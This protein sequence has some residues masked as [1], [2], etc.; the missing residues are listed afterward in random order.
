MLTV[1]NN[2]PPSTLNVEFSFWCI[3]CR[4]CSQQLPNSAATSCRLRRQPLAL[5]D[6]LLDGADHVERRL[7]QVVVFALDQPLEA[8]DGVSQVDE[9]AGRAGEYFGNMERLAQEALDLAR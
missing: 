3:D 9:L 1:R 8:A 4:R 6:R 2:M 5:V 7:R